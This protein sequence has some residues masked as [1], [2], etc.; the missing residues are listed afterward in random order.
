[1][2]GYTENVAYDRLPMCLYSEAVEIK[3]GKESANQVMNPELIPQYRLVKKLVARNTERNT[4]QNHLIVQLYLSFKCAHKK[5][6]L[7]CLTHQFIICA[8]SFYF[9]TPCC[10]LFSTFF[11]S[12]DSLH[13]LFLSL[14][15]NIPLFPYQ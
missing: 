15:Y 3:D 1:M 6:T 11:F 8:P 14:F 4:R 7:W 5:K 10:P 9:G 2:T 12:S 13:L